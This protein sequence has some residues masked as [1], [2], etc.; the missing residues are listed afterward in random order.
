MIAESTA[1]DRFTVA[2]LQELDDRTLAYHGLKVA[3]GRVLAAC[4][5]LVAL[6]MIAVLVVVVRLTSR[7][8]AIYRQTRVGQHGREFD[9]FKIRTMVIDAEATPV[10]SG[11][12]PA[13][14]RG[15]LG[16]AGSCGNCTWTNCRNSTT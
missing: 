4:M 12:L 2:Y 9:I 8:P 3:I 6:P 13:W 14:I 11:L 5:L 15:S 1:L 16:W 10:R 7:G